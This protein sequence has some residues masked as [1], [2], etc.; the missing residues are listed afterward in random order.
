MGHP[1]PAPGPDGL[2]ERVQALTAELD[3][4]GDPAARRSAHEL[5]GAIL[6]L[7]G[8]GLERIFQALADPQAMGPAIRE[9]L[10]G[11]GVVASLMLIHGLYPV[12][13]ETRV[14]EA[15]DKVRPYMASHGGNVELLGLEGG[16][17]RLRLQ[18][19]CNGCSASA[20]T[21][22]LAIKRALDEAA[23]DLLGIE[24]EGVT[25]PTHGPPLINCDGLA[26]AT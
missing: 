9:Q 4:I 24:V 19:T 14:T 18:G 2:V 11:D 20:A 13:L 17:A 16:V 21:L 10:T 5:I 22:E 6:E 7:Y 15:L 1:A 12:G 23:P 8:E 25:E 26:H 3:A